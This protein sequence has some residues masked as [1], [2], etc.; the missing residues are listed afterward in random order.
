MNDKKKLSLFDTI[1]VMSRGVS[2]EN[3][4]D[5]GIGSRK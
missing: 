5:T 1:D 4:Y 3:L 2:G